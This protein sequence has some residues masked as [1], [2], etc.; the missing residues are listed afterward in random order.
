[1]RKFLSN[2]SRSVKEATLP[3]WTLPMK[4]A[5]HS[6]LSG[7]EDGTVVSLTT[8]PARAGR[9]WIVL[10]SLFRQTVL[11]D[12]I[13]LVITEEEYPEGAAG[14]PESVRKYE[15][16]G[17]EIVT[18][19]LNLRCHN[20]YFHALQAYPE[21]LVVTVD[22]DCYYRRDTIARLLGLHREFPDAVC[23]NIA[24]KIDPGHFHEYSFWKKSVRRSAP[25]SRNVAL[26]FA[27]V[28]YPP[29][30]PASFFDAPLAM[31]LAPTTDDL[32]LKAVELTEGIGVACGSFFPKPLT[33]KS[34]QKV[35]LRSLNKGTERGNDRQWEALDA[36]FKLEEMI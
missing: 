35:S 4:G 30:M 33:I 9:L 5:S 31:S 28:L 16:L 32:W 15:P 18:S 36:H 21:A 17:L 1:M 14:L 26:G 27:G 34:S 13:V 24:A 23:C 10:E 29:H 3:V 20:K 25:D 8:F 11:P 22:D 12:R 6:P 19:P 7:R 2:I